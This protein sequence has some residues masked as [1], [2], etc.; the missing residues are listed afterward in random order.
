MDGNVRDVVPSIIA[1]GFGGFANAFVES[2][3]RLIAPPLSDAAVELAFE[4][5]QQSPNL[6]IPKGG[7]LGKPDNVSKRLVVPLKESV[8]FLVD[9]FL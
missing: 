7:C 6:V 3:P 2:D 8:L 9:L 4:G 5:I 1:N